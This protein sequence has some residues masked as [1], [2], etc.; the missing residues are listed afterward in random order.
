VDFR[1]EQH[2]HQTH[3]A[4]TDPEARLAHKGPGKEAKL[5]FVGYVLMEKRHGLVVEVML[6]P[7]HGYGGT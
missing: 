7:G 5:C 1:G 6:I 2:R 4:T 3:T